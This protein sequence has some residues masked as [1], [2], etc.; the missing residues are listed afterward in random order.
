MSVSSLTAALSLGIQADKDTAA[1]GTFQ[2]GLLTQSTMDSPAWDVIDAGAE[3]PGVSD[4]NTTNRSPDERFSY[5]VPISFGGLLYPRFIGMGLRGIGFDVSTT[6]NTTEL[7]HAFT[8]AAPEDVGY[9]TALWKLGTGSGEFERR[10][11]GVRLTQLQFSAESQ[12]LEV[13]GQGIGLVDGEALG[14]ETK[15]AEIAQKLMP[16]IGTYSLTIGGVA[17][18][19]NK[20]RTAQITIE[21]ALDESDYALWTQ[22]RIDLPQNS[23]GMRG[24]LGGIDIAY[25]EYKKINWGGTG[26]SSP[27]FDAVLSD[28]LTMK[29][30]SAA[31]ISGASVPYSIEF[32]I[33]S[34]QL[35]MSGFEASGEN[36][37]RFNLDWEMIDDSATP[38]EITLVND[39]DSYG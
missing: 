9:L 22:G 17:F 26:G 5:T 39:V 28:A 16:T 12:K 7:S 38:A 13:S 24:S 30:T 31:D 6:D 19:S 8:I 37:V 20:V 27:D 33:S 1:A 34:A 36:K 10:A 25:D 11:T 29:W 35:S 15:Q 21:Q 32:D 4:R 18:T 3:H 23:I 14:T 2:T